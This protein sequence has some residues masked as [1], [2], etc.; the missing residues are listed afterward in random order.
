MFVG[1]TRI[2]NL[3][4]E[5]K[6]RNASS[7]ERRERKKQRIYA[8]CNFLFTE[9]FMK[10]VMKAFERTHGGCR[11]AVSSFVGLDEL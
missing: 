8:L 1:A 11:V 9:L 6:T 4:L 5:L 7:G 10:L 3:R 2:A